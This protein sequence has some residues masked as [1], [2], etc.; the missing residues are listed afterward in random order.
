VGALAQVLRQLSPV[1]DPN[2]LIGPEHFADAGVYRLR[3]DLALVLTTDFFPPLV[4]DPYTF[5]QIAAANSLSDIYAMGA[6]PVAALN[7]VGFPDQELPIEV[8]GDILRGGADKVRQAGAVIVGGHSVRDAEVKYGL[9]V[10]G[11][12]DPRK[13]VSN[14]GARPGDRLILTKPLGSGV[15]TTAAKKG[16]IAPAD[17][18]QAIEVMTQLNDRAST[19]MLANAATA[20]TDITGFGLIGHAFE[21]ADASGVSITLQ[22]SAVPL[23]ER[24]IELARGGCLTRAHR[25]NR[26]FVGAMLSAEGIEAALLGVL[27]DAQTS[28]GLLISIDASRAA[29]LL[30]ALNHQ[31][32]PHAADIG[33][34]E[35]AKPITLTVL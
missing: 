10:T 33:W 4:D 22:A 25:S 35:T 29:A 17:L 27:C 28:G 34:V 9:A 2:L 8:L 23:M 18:S 12:V 14:R 6:R 21:L 13:F 3:E 24:V 19:A 7:I 32:C 11:V 16:L 5:G 30:A 20:A 26:E 1:A 15:L 31:G